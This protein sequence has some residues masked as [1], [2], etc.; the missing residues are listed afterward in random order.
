MD[1]S[2]RTA[3]ALKKGMMLRK[4]TYSDLGEYCKVSGEAVR[5]WVAI[6][7]RI[8]DKHVEKV[9]AFTGIEIK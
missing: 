7:Q 8:P 3:N 5:Q 4:F 9:Q 1:I 2:K 6:H